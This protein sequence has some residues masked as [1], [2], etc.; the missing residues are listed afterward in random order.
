MFFNLS[1]LI[2]IIFQHLIAATKIRR[3]NVRG[4]FTRNETFIGTVGSEFRARHA[5]VNKN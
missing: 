2:I 3:E 4:E 1:T 5:K